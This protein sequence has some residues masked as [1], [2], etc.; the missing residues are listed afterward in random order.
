MEYKIYHKTYTSAVTTA[1]TF[2]IRKGFNIKDNDWFSEITVGNG[3]PSIGSYIKHHLDLYKDDKLQKK[4]LHFQ[5]YGMESG[6]FELNLYI[7]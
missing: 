4:A 5:I 3:K 1:K 6:N 7:N 2:A